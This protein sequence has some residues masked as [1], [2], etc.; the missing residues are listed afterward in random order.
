MTWTP[1]PHA[2]AVDYANY[3]L[4]HTGTL[5]DQVIGAAQVLIGHKNTILKGEWEFYENVRRICCPWVL[6]WD[7]NRNKWEAFREAEAMFNNRAV[8]LEILGRETPLELAFGVSAISSLADTGEVEHHLSNDPDYQPNEFDHYDAARDEA[9]SGFSDAIS[10]ITLGRQL[11]NMPETRPIA[12]DELKEYRRR[13]NKNAAEKRNEPYRQLH[14]E[15]RRYLAENK[16]KSIRNAANLFYESLPENRQ[17]YR[18]ADHAVRNLSE[19]MYGKKSR[20][21]ATPT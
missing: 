13:L 4:E 14:W 8:V 15:F 6:N 17:I 10:I 1:E 19:S 11:K 16:I 12:D 3:F 2:R 20:G 18:S 5:K 7:S 9:F 21:L